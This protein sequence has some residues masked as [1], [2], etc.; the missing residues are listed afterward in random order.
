MSKDGS[1]AID[2]CFS[3]I[4]LEMPGNLKRD[5]ET[6]EDEEKEENIFLICFWK[7]EKGK[8]ILCDYSENVFFFLPCF[9]LGEFIEYG[10]NK[11]YIVSFKLLVLNIFF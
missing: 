2:L 5:Q 8:L 10:W 3:L 11:I 7:Y 4:C 6:E 9:L 1:D